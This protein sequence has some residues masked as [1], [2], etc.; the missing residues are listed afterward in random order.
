MVHE[1]ALLKA[2]RHAR[3]TDCCDPA[4]TGLGNPVSVHDAAS[5]AVTVIAA[6]HPVAPAS[7]A[8]R[9]KALVPAVFRVSV[10]V[11]TPKVNA[12]QE[13]MACGSVDV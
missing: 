11:E 10:Q 1:D 13:M 6:E 7:V 4:A 3:M 8:Q 5:A 12:V 9:L 2:S